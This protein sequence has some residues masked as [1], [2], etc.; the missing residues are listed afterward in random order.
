MFNEAIVGG[1]KFYCNGEQTV[2]YKKFVASVII[3]F[4]QNYPETIK[5]LEKIIS[6]LEWNV[7]DYDILYGLVQSGK[8]LA[9]AF[10]L[11]LIT[12]KYRRQ[13]IFMTKNLCSIR[14]DI[15]YKLTN[16]DSAI[17]K[18]I[19]EVLSDPVFQKFDENARQYFIP[20]V[21]ELKDMKMGTNFEPRQIPVFIMNK[22]N[23]SALV[24]CVKNAEIEKREIVFIIDEYH[25]WFTEQMKFL[26]ENGV[27]KIS[28][29]AMLHWLHQ[30]RKDHQHSILGVTAT[31]FRIMADSQLFPRQDQ[32]SWL[33]N[34]RPFENAYYY[35]FI[36]NGN[37]YFRQIEIEVYDESEIKSNYVIDVLEKILDERETYGEQCPFVLIPVEY[38][39]KCQVEL[40][41]DIDLYFENQLV[42]VDVF[43]QNAETELKG[44]FDK[45][46][47]L[48]NLDEYKKGGIFV[49][50]AK[51]TV[52]TGVTVKSTNKEQLKYLFGITDQIMPKFKYLEHD[53]QALRIC[54]WY[55]SQHQ[56]RIWVPRSQEHLFMTSIWEL[57]D[58]IM[59]IYDGHPNSITNLKVPMG[60]IKNL[61][62]SKTT[63]IYKYQNPG[64][65]LKPELT[66]VKPEGIEYL[67]TIVTKVGSR[68]GKYANSKIS[69]LYNHAKEQHEL[70]RLLDPSTQRN[71]LLI[72][73]KTDRH[74]EILRT[75]FQPSMTNTHWQVNA[76][77]YGPDGPNTLVRDCYVVKFVKEWHE[78]TTMKDILNCYTSDAV[79]NGLAFKIFD[80]RWVVC[81][82]TQASLQHKYLDK[83]NNKLSDQHDDIVQ[84]VSKLGTTL[85]NGHA[86]NPW[87]FFLR[88]QKYRGIRYNPKQYSKYWKDLSFK[89]KIVEIFN[90]T[91]KY[92]IKFRQALD[93]CNEYF[94]T[95]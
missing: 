25:A 68:A 75:C 46:H 16:G 31:P 63:D 4:G 35:G 23:Y 65:I 92:D 81:R 88:L 5:S 53:I 45:I 50:I 58:H 39:N 22:A 37:P 73:Y 44:F 79:I 70:R 84:N 72:G 9:I 27:T 14:E 10:L 40:K 86:K 1:N 62:G 56:S 55:P 61:L 7:L 93:I 54:G 24:K 51:R 6:D 17:N 71:R 18:I 42:Y 38:M 78:R 29:L 20:K 89:H 69:D 60:E 85:N 91:N 64:G 82:I 52:D 8:S 49:M 83:V 95:H 21:V 47:E 43:N 30:K 33:K 77:L 90:S 34:D 66:N 19:T 94:T 87:T 13:A 74:H 12:Y 3:K 36:N 26:K 80:D 67:D 76:F 11:W 41:E 28:G 59:K 57:T 15:L 48:P 2:I 32:I